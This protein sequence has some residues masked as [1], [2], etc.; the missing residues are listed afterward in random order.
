LIDDCAGKG[1][2]ELLTVEGAGYSG[3][4]TKSVHL[5]FL[6]QQLVHAAADCQAGFI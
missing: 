3:I 1:N 2:N 4:V 5:Y 6:N